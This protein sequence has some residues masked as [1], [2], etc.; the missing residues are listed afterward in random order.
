MKII[1][2]AFS[3]WRKQ[4][5]NFK[6]M[7]FRNAILMLFNNLTRQYA[8]IYVRRLGASAQDISLL[9]SASSFITMI[10]AIINIKVC[11]ID[12]NLSNS[13]LQFMAAKKG[14]YL[15]RLSLRDFIE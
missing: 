2:D 6:L 8:T 4:S 7:L 5:V 3:F 14:R 12:S 15:R 9:E 1:D 11:L 13:V 10:L